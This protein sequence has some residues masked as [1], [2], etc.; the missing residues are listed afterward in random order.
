[1]RN[2][3]NNLKSYFDIIGTKFIKLW[4]HYILQSIY[5]AIALGVFLLAIG[6]ENKVAISSLAAT[7]F[8]VFATPKENSAKTKNIIGGHLVCLLCGVFFYLSVPLPYYIQYPLVVAVA[9]FL[10]AGLDLEHPPAAGSALA[11]V[12]HE[13]GVREFMFILA[14]AVI[15]G[16]LH[17][18]LREK[19]RD[20]V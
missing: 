15:L 10:M 14:G 3:I 4:P 2:Y 19:L 6:E 9:I 8:I 18:L 17:S 13:V 20:L 7:T 12:M 16:L 5:G 11:V 1:M